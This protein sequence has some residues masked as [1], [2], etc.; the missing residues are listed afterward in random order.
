MELRNCGENFSGN[1]RSSVEVLKWGRVCG[2]LSEV[3]LRF[4]THIFIHSSDSI[5]PFIFHSDSIPNEFQS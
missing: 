4:D 2:A 3:K 5:S 1:T